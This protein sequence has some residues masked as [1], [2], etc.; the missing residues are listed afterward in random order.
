M[1]FSYSDRQ[2]CLKVGLF[3]PLHSLSF[4]SSTPFQSFL[5]LLP[6]PFSCLHVRN[7]VSNLSINTATY[8]SCCIVAPIALLTDN[9]KSLKSRPHWRQNVAR[10]QIVD[11][12]VSLPL[13]PAS[14]TICRAY[15]RQIGDKLSHGDIL[16]QV[17]TSHYCVTS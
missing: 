6:I 14:A 7:S 17:W 16:S 15:R 8:L 4:Y 13:A 12:T 9:R 2:S 10:R 5:L 1:I 3:S 11:E